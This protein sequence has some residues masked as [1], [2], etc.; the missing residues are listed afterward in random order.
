MKKHAAVFVASLILLSFCSPLLASE[1]PAPITQDLKAQSVTLP[2]LSQPAQ[3]TPAQPAQCSS[4][5]S[6]LLPQLKMTGRECAQ[7]CG[8]CCACAQALAGGPCI[9]WECC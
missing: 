2:F 1:A 8:G 5:P 9:D 7:T 6:K 3:A 4:S